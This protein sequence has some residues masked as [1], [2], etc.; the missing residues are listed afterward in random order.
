MYLPN[1][2][3]D[4]FFNEPDRIVEYAMAQEFY[5]PANKSIEAF[6]QNIPTGYWPGKRTKPLHVINESLTQALTHK[7]GMLFFGS[8]REITVE[9][10]FQL[11][12]PIQHK[13]IKEGWIH[14]DDKVMYAGVVYLS[15]NINLNCGTSLYRQ[16]TLGV[17]AARK[18][19][20]PRDLHYSPNFRPD[21]IDYIK[22]ELQNNN[23]QF[24]ETVRFNA[25]YNR[26]IGYSS[27]Y[28]HGV[29][30]YHGDGNESRLTLVFFIHAI[31]SDWFPIPQSKLITL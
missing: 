4:N 17:D 25:I 11:I 23:S 5:S 22:H 27:S 26:M 19:I 21:D 31:K 20:E 2:C 10:Y 6:Q 15:K 16:K 29:R 8:G 12:D 14:V 28:H 13:D 7:L 9:S 18:Y 24:E 3:V 30:D 1:V